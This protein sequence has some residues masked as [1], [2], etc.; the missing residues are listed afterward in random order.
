MKP[1]VSL[2]AL[3]V[4]LGG[5]HAATPSAATPAPAT[6]TVASVYDGD[7]F[8][9]SSGDKVRLKWINTP[10][11]KPPEA[12]AVE[13]R[14]ATQAFVSGKTLTFVFGTTTRDGYGRLVA[15]VKIGEE[16][17]S[18]HLL[19]R[20]MGHLFVIPPDDTDMTPFIAAQER[21]RAAKR[22]IW[23][24]AEFQGVLHITSFHANA[25]GDDRENVN[26]EY[27]RVCNVSSSSLDLSGFK[28][29]DISGNAYTFPSM[30]VPPGHT[31]KV[32]SGKGT[33]QTDPREQLAVYLGSPDPIWNNKDDRAT[34]SDRFGKVVDARTHS[35]QQETQ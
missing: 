14:E 17:L 18:I 19:E 32:H 4:A 15:G 22:G 20:G 2:L 31:F 33:H 9:L 8:T 34:I 10:E 28:I 30:V 6:G 13:A 5:A 3:L 7:T 35:V 1:V 24:T 27:L 16:N 25:D 29:V 26:G 21:A 11:I 12:Y 23:S